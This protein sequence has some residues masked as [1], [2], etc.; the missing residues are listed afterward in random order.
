MQEN[1]QKN[2]ITLE[3]IKFDDAGLVPAIA[4]DFKTG[5]ILMFAWMNQESISMTIKTKFAHYFSRSRNQLWKKGETS[6]NT[7]IV[8]EILIDCDKDCLILKI[9]QKGNA[10]H[11]GAKSCFFRNLLL[12]TIAFLALLSGN[13]YANQDNKIDN[14]TIFSESNMIYPLVKAARLYSEKKSAI[15]SIN[16]NNSLQ[17]IQNIND[18]ERADVFIASHPEWI[19]TLKQKGLVDVYNL[20]NIAKDKLVLVTS[21]NNKKVDIT[22]INQLSDINKIL[23]TLNNDNIPIIIDEINTSLGNYGNDIMLQAKIA[24]QK[25][26]HRVLEDRKSIIELIND[27][28]E[29]CGIVFASSIAD[30]NNI[31]VLKEIENG[32][33][34]YQALVIAGDN[35]GKA[36]DFLKFIKSSDEIKKDFAQSGF[37]VD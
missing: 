10:C 30:H 24:H 1:L 34:Y 32:E 15:V 26:F 11:T 12:I 25:V 5:Q 29:Y 27:G 21:K 4:Q 17:L 36:R 35:M 23:R 7:Q 3:A 31:V 33:I 20:T 2:E 16:F 9:E 19:K 8:K 37:V 18:G 14:L 6:G 28:D 13:V 22:K